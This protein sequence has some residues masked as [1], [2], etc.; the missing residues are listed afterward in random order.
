MCLDASWSWVWISIPGLS[1]LN[2]CRNVLFPRHLLSWTVNP[3]RTVTV[4]RHVCIP[5]SNQHSF[6]SHCVLE[7]SCTELKHCTVWPKGKACSLKV[8]LTAV[9]LG[10][11]PT[12][13]PGIGTAQEPRRASSY[14]LVF[15]SPLPVTHLNWP[16]CQ[17]SD[18]LS[19][20]S[21]HGHLSCQAVN[22]SR[23]RD[24]GTEPKPRK[25]GDR[26]NMRVTTVMG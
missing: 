23:S 12:V 20:P 3:L 16:R 4:S 19:L 7:K 2:L 14:L 21:A 24:P 11:Q 26:Q 10:K 25:P 15:F 22:G 6:I 18:G 9:H 1:H 17:G 8:S 13:Q 5:L